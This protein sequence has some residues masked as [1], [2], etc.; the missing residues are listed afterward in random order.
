MA[1]SALAIQYLVLSGTLYP[2]NRF[3][4]R[5]SYLSDKADLYHGHLPGPVVAE[6]VDDA[7]NMLLR[8]AVPASTICLEGET[9]RELRIMATIP[10]PGHTRSIRLMRDGVQVL[11]LRVSDS[12]P[13]LALTWQPAGEVRGRQTITWEARHPE[14]LP[15]TCFVRYSLHDDGERWQRLS[16]SGRGAGR[17]RF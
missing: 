16:A 3:E 6:L 15:V 8:H 14:D 4:Y 9:S 10:F 17:R 12:A 2:D 11:D 7:G 13:E 1:D 5:A